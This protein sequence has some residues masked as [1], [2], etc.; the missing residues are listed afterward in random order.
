V[1]VTSYDDSAS[2]FIALFGAGAPGADIAPPLGV[3]DLADV[4]AF[5]G[6]FVGGCD[7]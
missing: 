6:A 4:Q 1:K 5:I 7:L 2:S 3:L